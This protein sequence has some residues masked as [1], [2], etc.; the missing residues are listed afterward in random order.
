MEKFD[1]K[2]LD[3]AHSGNVRKIKKLI[4]LKENISERFVCNMSLI[5]SINNYDLKMFN[6]LLNNIKIRVY[7]PKNR[8]LKEAINSYL[9]TNKVKQKNKALNMILKIVKDKEV[10]ANLNNQEE[11]T[12]RLKLEQILLTINIKN[13]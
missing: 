5:S 12:T 6:F 11:E 9:K 10:Q 4:P 2:F 1:E 13:F 8:P 7:F 3:Y